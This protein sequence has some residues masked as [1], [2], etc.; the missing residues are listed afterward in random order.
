MLPCYPSFL[1]LRQY[2]LLAISDRLIDV[3]IKK[4]RKIGHSAEFDHIK[5]YVIGNDIR[6]INWKATARKIKSW[7]ITFVM[8]ETNKYIA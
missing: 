8:N 7:L 5:E 6:T 1:K 2:E 3:G 4:L